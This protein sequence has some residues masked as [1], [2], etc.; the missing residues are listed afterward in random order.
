[1]SA[2]FRRGLVVGKFCPLHRGHE[3]LI[4]RAIAACDEVLV[5]SYTKPEF[6]GCGRADREG[7]LAALFPQVRALVV[8]DAALGAICA[9]RG[10]TP[11]RQVPHND[12][13]EEEHRSFCG[14][15]CL[16]VF[17]TSV[18]AVFTSEDYGDGF[19]A[20]LTDYFRV[21]AASASAVT[22]VCVDQ[23]R[24][25]IPV[26]GTAVRADVHAHRALLAPEVYASFV[27]RICLL[28]GESSGKSSL[29]A[30]LADRLGTV[31]AAEYG[32]ELWDLRASQGRRLELPDMLH[33]GQVQCRRERA[34]AGRAQRWLVCDTAPLT[35][36][37]YSMEMF[38]QADAA[39]LELAERRYDAV[40]VC[41]PDFPFV[42]DGTRRDDAFRHQQHAWYLRALEQRGIGYTV[43]AGPLVARVEQALGALTAASNSEM[44]R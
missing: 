37:F 38:G 3:L 24:L 2:R 7:W 39:L 27:R 12:A 29:A 10:I 6:D 22:H 20:S 25:A 14:W 34:L 42:Q 4:G 40:F 36:Y 35:T 28:G 9:A 41:L 23:A 43:L 13:P 15:L 31:W 21:H 11:A 18:D 16:T 30:A 32:R 1:M 26:S 8:D 5:I 19:A 33:I 44:K 17:G